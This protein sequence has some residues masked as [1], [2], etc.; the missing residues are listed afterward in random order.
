MRIVGVGVLVGVVLLI[1]LQPQFV[2]NLDQKTYDVMT[3][4]VDP[5][6]PSG[7]VVLVPIDENSLAQYGRWPWPRDLLGMLV[8]RILEA[9]ASTVALDMMFPEPD[10]RAPT[11]SPPAKAAAARA[12]SDSMNTL[13]PKTADDFLA[14]SLAIGWVIVG[15]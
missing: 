11:L 6:R 5:G 9:G 14:E 13:H 3:R 15:Y 4:R 2:A 7:R 12:A 1:L 8:R 10:L